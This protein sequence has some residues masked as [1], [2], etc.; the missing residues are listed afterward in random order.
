[1]VLASVGDSVS[2]EIGISK[3]ITLP[4]LIALSTALF[5]F[6]KKNGLIEKYGL[7][8]PQISSARMLFTFR[9]SFC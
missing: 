5:F 8:K 2:E 6:V 9:L 1:M 4:I 3:I 7:C